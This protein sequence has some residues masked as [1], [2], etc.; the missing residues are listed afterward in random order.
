[1]REAL[2]GVIALLGGASCGF[3]RAG[4]GGAG[5]DLPG[6]GDGGGGGDSASVD[7]G[8]GASG[9]PY[10]TGAVSFFKRA[11]CPTGWAPFEP[12]NGRTILP[13]IGETPP[14]TKNGEPLASG[15]DRKHA[16][17]WSTAFAI[18]KFDFIVFDGGNDGVGAGGNVPFAGTTEPASSKLPYVQLLVCKKAAGRGKKQLPTGMQIYF[19][20]G[21]CPAGFHQTEE[22]QGRVTV[23]LPKGAGA[24]QSYGAAAMWG[25]GPRVHIH[26]LTGTL[27]TSPHGMAV[28]SGCCNGGFASNGKYTASATTEPAPGGLPWVE[29]VG[30]TKD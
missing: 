30:C 13:T 5:G 15:E 29:L 9:D 27:E 6:D 19:D 11:S 10:P 20:A 7:G 8:P 2:I 24:D 28:V 14:G 21:K 12:A 3:D 18:S 1:M 25:S 4:L 17:K 16:H 23:G 22:T 26:A